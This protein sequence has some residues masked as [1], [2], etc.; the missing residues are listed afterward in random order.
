M[1]YFLLLP[2][3]FFLTPIAHAELTDLRATSVGTSGYVW[4][5]FDNQ[6]SQV[7]L[8]QTHNGVRLRVHGVDVSSRSISPA[9]TD[10]VRAVSLVAETGGAVIELS[11]AR[12]WTGLQAEVRQGGVLITVDLGAASAP[13]QAEYAPEVSR[14][15]AV[16]PDTPTLTEPDSTPGNS[17]DDVT[18]AR[19]EEPVPAETPAEPEVHEVAAELASE[20]EP[21]TPLGECE[22]LALAVADD[23][24]NER[25]LVPHAGCLAEQGQTREASGIYRQVLA[26]E[27]ENYAA[28]VGLAEIERRAGN[29]DAALQL[30]R[31]AA[32]NARSDAQAAAALDRARALENGQ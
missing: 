27:P 3:L 26:F 1:R 6:P 29:A 9:H 18:Q 23:P 10:L 25:L 4:F 32:S 31:Q 5:G 22:R 14:P 11:A 15:A 30:Y 12:E 19:A 7:E 28:A 13:E 8:E 16:E 17:Q 21:V 2:C 24:W 20:P